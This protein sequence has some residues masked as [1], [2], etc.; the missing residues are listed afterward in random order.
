MVL[1]YFEKAT[2]QQLLQICLYEDCFIDD[3]Y[4]AAREL[5]LR[6][7]RDE[8]LADLIRLWGEGKTSFQIAVELGL[9]QGSVSWQLEKHDLYGRR[10]KKDGVN[11]VSRRR[12]GC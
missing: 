10:I 5:Q 1:K 2:K 3:K 8:Y 9:D 7:W 6:Q 11:Y 12:L 4:Q